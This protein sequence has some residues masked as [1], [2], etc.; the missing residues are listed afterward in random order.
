MTDNVKIT[1]STERI[2]YIVY[3]NI[4]NLVFENK[5]IVYGGFVRDFIICDH[6][7]KLYNQINSYSISAFWNKLIHPETAARTI[8]ANDIDVCM[9]SEEDITQFIT[10]LQNLFC[11][12]SGFDNVSSSDIVVDSTMKYFGAPITTHR[13]INYKIIVGKVPYVFSGVELSFDIDIIMPK[14]SNN[15]PPFYKTDLLSNIFLMNKQGIVISKN[16]GTII[17]KMSQL[18]KQK[19]THL[20]MKDIVEFKTQIA[21]RDKCYLDHISGSFLYNCEVY[22][23]IHKMMFRTFNW[24]ITNLPFEICDFKDNNTATI[25]SICLSNFKKKNKII[26]MYIDNSTKTDKVCSVA[27]DYCLFKYFETQIETSKH[28]KMNSTDEFEFRCPM[29]NIMN[30]KLHSDN[31]T[32]TINNK[33]NE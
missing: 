25:C 21:L 14:N 15:Q 6:Y 24:N 23:R 9:Y 8:V 27:H 31:I 26:K 3:E 5:G 13:K 20:I 32:E 12:D 33:M 22:H 16:T 19:I 17:D 30:F 18:D 10:D 1:F 4:K 11:L 7:K 28:N 2:K 29:R